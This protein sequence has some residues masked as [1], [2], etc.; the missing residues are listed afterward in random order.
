MSSVTSTRQLGNNSLNSVVSF[1]RFARASGLEVGL[2][3]TNDTLKAFES[4]LM[5]DSKFFRHTLKSICCGTYNDI[6]LFDE[7]YAM[8][9]YDE[10]GGKLIAKIKNEYQPKES[11][12]GSLI[13]TGNNRQQRE[14]GEETDAKNMSGADYMEKIRKTDFCKLDDIDEEQFDILAQELWRQMS[15]R[16]KRR[17]K[18][19]NKT[20]KIDFSRTIRRSISKGG[21]PAE[22]VIRQRKLIKKR[23]VVLLDVSGS[24]DKYSFYLLKFI[25]ALKNY[26]ETIEAFVFSTELNYITPYLRK[27]N[28]K[29]T[30]EMIAEQVTSWSSGTRIGKCL[31]DFNTSYAKS[32]LSRPAI[33]IILSDGLDTGDPAILEKAIMD[34]KLKTKQL[35]WL[36]PLKGMEGYEPVQ[37][38]MS[39]ALPYVDE[40]HSAHNLE[41]L[42]ELENYLSY[43]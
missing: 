34:I 15:Y 1:M 37:R 42:L 10:G 6:E 41:S 5:Y 33:V 20:G 24:M 28:L 2:G 14:S 39:S 23:L 36:N 38:G 3:E 32:I 9:W 43:V 19:G 29:K 18:I 35:I 16:M 30:L 11:S 7:I 4:G 8:Y 31:E 40:F 27:N 17:M 25:F 21:W 12:Q 22:L 26:F 13:L